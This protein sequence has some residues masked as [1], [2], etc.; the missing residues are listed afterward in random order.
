MMEVNSMIALCQT[1]MNMHDKALETI[2][3][4]IKGIDE[5]QVLP[6]FYYVKGMA[7]NYKGLGQLQES[8]SA[9]LHCEKKLLARPVLD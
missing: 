5:S 6:K 2:E 1:K 8:A 9:F 4:A 7:L 3:Q